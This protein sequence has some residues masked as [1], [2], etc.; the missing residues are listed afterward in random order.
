MTPRRFRGSGIKYTA[1]FIGQFSGIW[2]VVTVA[3]VLVA[4]IS[5]YLAVAAFVGGA[6]QIGRGLLLSL[7]LQTALTIVAVVILAIFTTHR[8]AGPWIAVRRAC[9]RVRDGDLDSRLR[10]RNR[11]SYLRAVEEDFNSM[12]ESMRERRME[13]GH[14]SSAAAGEASSPDGRGTPPPA[15]T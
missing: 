2:L 12:L 5:S 8:L 1:S 4:S 15:E 13:D 10:I 3:A 6:D 14:G 11:D 9:Q 7:I